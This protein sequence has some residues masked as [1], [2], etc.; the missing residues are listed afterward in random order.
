MKKGF[1]LIEMIAVI[2]IIGLMSIIIMPNI[3]NQVSN[4]KGE[5]SEATKKLLFSAAERYMEDNELDYPKISSN[6]Y[7]V[8]LQ[9]LINNNYLSY[10]IKDVQ[11]GENMET[12]KRVKTTVN[13]Y[14]DFDNFT[15]INKNE[16]CS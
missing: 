1:T 7:C 10:P 13:E 9:T 16:S 15:L 2:G 8:K 12:S 6:V 14:G 4:K 5:I 11:S 3:I